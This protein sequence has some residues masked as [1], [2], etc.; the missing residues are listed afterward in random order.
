MTRSRYTPAGLRLVIASLALA[1][2]AA[3][4]AA[5]PGAAAQAQSRY[6]QDMADCNSGRSN[7]DGPTC[8]LEARNALAEARRSGLVHT[9]ESYQSNAQ[10]RCLV[11]QGID[12]SACEGR[13][14]GEG[15]ME[16]SVRAG[17]ILRESITVVPAN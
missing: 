7:Q 11:L 3:A 9:P 17:G 1:T 12:R 5:E 2:S 4:W 8:R 10:Q 14:R 13:M 6:R 16:G 15:R